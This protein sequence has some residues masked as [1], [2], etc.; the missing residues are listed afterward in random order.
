MTLFEPSTSGIRLGYRG[1]SVSSSGAGSGGS[2]SLLTQSIGGGPNKH[3]S[4]SHSTLNTATTHDSM[5][6]TKIPKS[7]SNES[8]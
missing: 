5:M 3:L 6:H 8:L 2:G 7:P 4:A 1:S